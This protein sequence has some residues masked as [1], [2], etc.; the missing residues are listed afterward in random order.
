MS[1]TS[2]IYLEK[3]CQEFNIPTVV[4]DIKEIKF[5]QDGYNYIINLGNNTHWVAL[6]VQGNYVAYFDSFGVVPPLRVITLISK[7]SKAKNAEIKYMYNEQ[8]IQN[9]QSGYCGEYAFFFLYYM[10]YAKGP[11]L[12]RFKKLQ[13]AF[14]GDVEENKTVL[15]NR[16]HKI[17]LYN[18]KLK[19][20]P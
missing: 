11:F 13:R 2:N 16:L 1:Q 5:I 19:F 9:L 3:K 7:Y 17:G 4:C 20:N 12:T 14:K 6:F 18:G 10:N 15:L 8:D